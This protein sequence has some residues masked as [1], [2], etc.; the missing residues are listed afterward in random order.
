MGLRRLTD[1]T[2]SADV[3][4]GGG[5]GCLGLVPLQ[6]LN[7]LGCIMAFNHFP[8]GDGL[9]GI[10]QRE[11]LVA[12]RLFLTDSG[13]YLLPVDGFEQSEKME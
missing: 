11:H 6:T 7:M 8:N 9:L 4:G 3:L 2:F 10:W 12:Q 13:H 5:S 1:A